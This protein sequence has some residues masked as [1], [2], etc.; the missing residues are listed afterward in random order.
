M[1]PISSKC[2]KN[3]IHFQVDF[4]APSPL[5]YLHEVSEMMNNIFVSSKPKTLK[6]DGITQEDNNTLTKMDCVCVC[7]MFYVELGGYAS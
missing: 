1:Q 7:V 3:N 4:N 5:E 2:I 6:D